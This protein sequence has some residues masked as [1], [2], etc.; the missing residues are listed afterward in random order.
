MML[1]PARKRYINKVGT[2][3]ADG[4]VEVDGVAYASPSE[5]ATAITAKRTGGWWFFL[6]D[7]ANRTSLRKFVVITLTRWLS[8]R[9]TIQMKTMMMNEGMQNGRGVRS[10]AV[11]SGGTTLAVLV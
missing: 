1:F 3:L 10:S 9:R 5:A 11:A 2:L 7:Q 8:M 4:Q 6:T